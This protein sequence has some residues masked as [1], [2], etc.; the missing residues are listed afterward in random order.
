MSCHLL[1]LR[2][3]V[4]SIRELSLVAWSFF[5]SLSHITTTYL[6]LCQ[7]S[8]PIQLDCFTLRA[9]SPLNSPSIHVWQSTFIICH[10]TLSCLPVR[11]DSIYTLFAQ[12]SNVDIDVDLFWSSFY[13]FYLDYERKGSFLSTVHETIR[14]PT[15]STIVYIVEHS[16]WGGSFRNPRNGTWVFRGVGSN[17]GHWPDFDVELFQ[18]VMTAK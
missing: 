5:S 14:I 15:P 17:S 16:R 8:L 11:L 6:G 13:T 2:F 10:N 1:T 7:F 4:I 3:C 18:E 12:D 9:S